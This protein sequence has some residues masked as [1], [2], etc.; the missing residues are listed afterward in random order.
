[1]APSTQNPVKSPA[2]PPID[3]EN[4]SSKLNFW[5]FKFVSKRYQI[6]LQMCT[7]FSVYIESPDI[8]LRNLKH[9]LC[10]IIQLFLAKSDS[11]Q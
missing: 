10:P 2:V 4:N 9:Q 5:F 11:N 3:T 1:M 8:Y 7:K 6:N